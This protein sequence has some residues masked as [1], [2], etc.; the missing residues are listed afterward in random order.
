LDEIKT[1]IKQTGQILDHDIELTFQGDDCTEENA[2]LSAT[3]LS[4]KSD[5]LAI[6]G[7][8]C[9]ADLPITLPILEDAGLVA[10]SPSPS[11]TDAFQHLVFAIEQVAIRQPDGTIVIPRT[12]LHL[13]V[14][15]KP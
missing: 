1:A 7:P 13:A 5:L 9:P 14:Q 4:G 8:T 3:L 12:A 10:L 2:R 15:N 11:A 6:I